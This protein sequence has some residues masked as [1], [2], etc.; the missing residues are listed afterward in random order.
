MGLSQTPKALVPASLGSG[1]T[2]IDSHSASSVTSVSRNN[3]FSATYQ[4]YL[5]VVEGVL[6]TETNIRL[7]LRASG[8]DDTGNN[9][10]YS[11][12]TRTSG[13]FD[14]GYDGG[15]SSFESGFIATSP[16]N[17]RIILSNPFTASRTSF[18]AHSGAVGG[19]RPLVLLGGWHNLTTSYD[20]FNLSAG[21]HSFTGT[22]RTY[23]L[24]N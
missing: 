1:L 23:G 15:A 10:G 12:M 13:S 2:L 24:A 3:V 18:T 7:R 14:S 19:T 20:G 16:S 5:I 4:N 17:S 6:S 21:G 8:T 9:Y 11:I 22:I